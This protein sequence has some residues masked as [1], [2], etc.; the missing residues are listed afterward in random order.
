MEAVPMIELY[1]WEPVSHSLRV[2]ISLHEIGADFRSHYV[3]LMKFEQFSTDYL[4][5]NPAGQVP[6]LKNDEVALFESALINEYLAELY[7]EAGL[8]PTGPLAWYNTQTWS[9]Y[10]D[11]NLGPSL[12]TLG[13]SSFLV[14]LLKTLDR[15][16]L[17]AS[18]AAIPL[19]ERRAGWSLAVSG[20]YPADGLRNSA[21]KVDLVTR[22]MESI[23]EESEWLVGDKYS[24]A[25]IDT[26]AMIHG[27]RNLAPTVINETNTPKT[28]DW[29]SRIAARAAV[30]DALATES[31]RYSGPLYAPGPEHSRWG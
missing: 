13:C 24:I 1:H 22:R 26:F 20:E 7:P 19:S 16:K 15:K 28:L 8:A 14:P 30:K 10:V 3:D 23:L 6:V 2:L 11:Y 9:K 29:Y 17:E 4:S 27:L 12:A 5:I 25:D 31:E 18:I 21:R